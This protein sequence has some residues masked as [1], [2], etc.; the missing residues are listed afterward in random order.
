M[1]KINRIPVNPDTY[2]LGGKLGGHKLDHICEEKEIEGHTWI[3]KDFIDTFNKYKPEGAELWWYKTTGF[4][5]GTSGY[6]IVLGEY[7]IDHCIVCLH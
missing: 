4:L 7:V 6:A 3:S 5:C 1:E 2:E